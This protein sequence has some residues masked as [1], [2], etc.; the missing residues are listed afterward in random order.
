[1]YERNGR[2]SDADDE[3][4]RAIALDSENLNI[5]NNYAVFLYAESRLDEAIGQWEQVIDRAP[6]HFAALVNLGSALSET[7]K[8]HEAIRHYE[9]ANGLRPTYFGYVNLGTAHAQ[10]REYPAAVR[11]YRDAIRI[12]AKGSLAWGNLAFVLYW[13]NG[14]DSETTAAFEQAIELAEA[15]R[16]R[17]PRDALTHS[18]LALYYAITGESHLA[19]ERIET[20]MTLAES[21]GEVMAAAA[22]V[23]EILGLR[24]QALEHVNTALELGLSRERL[25]S[26]PGLSGLLADPRISAR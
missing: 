4:R 10:L 15:A 5:R 1:V 8:V 6:D 7:G 13:M 17:D 22:E 12:D 20:A 16:E 19:L 14:L 21:S 25:E 18:D 23:Y 2:T 26:N 11:A 3:Y 9:R 24:E